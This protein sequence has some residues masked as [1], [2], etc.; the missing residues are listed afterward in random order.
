VKGRDGVK[1]PRL[2]TLDADVNG[3]VASSTDTS[4]SGRA[5]AGLEEV[6]RTPSTRRRDDQRASTRHGHHPHGTAKHSRD[7]E[8]RRGSPPPRPEPSKKRCPKPWAGTTTQVAAALA[9]GGAPEP[10]R[11]ATARP[12]TPGR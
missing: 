3:A 8:T 1:V 2:V 4:G 5:A 6:F 12:S 11:P 10:V 9:G 7:A